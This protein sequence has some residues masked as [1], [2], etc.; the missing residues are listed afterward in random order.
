MGRGLSQRDLSLRAGLNET[1][2]KAIE[3]GKSE[4]PREN[5]LRALAKILDCEVSDLIKVDTQAAVAVAPSSIYG[6]RIEAARIAQ[7]LAIDQF[8]RNL[9][10]SVQLLALWESGEVT[11]D[12][13]GLARLWRA[14]VP[15]DWILHGDQDAL[16]RVRQR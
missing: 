9:G 1:A 11:P 16:Q 10:I 14:G 13:T 4:S 3:T 8:A 7:G 12:S 15:S 5:T 6:A 2:V